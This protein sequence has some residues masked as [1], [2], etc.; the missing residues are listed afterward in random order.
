MTMDPKPANG[1]VAA[2]VAAADKHPECKD[3]HPPSATPQPPM[4]M[5]RSSSGMTTP[6]PAKLPDGVVA[7]LVADTGLPPER[8]LQ[9]ASSPVRQPDGAAAAPGVDVGSPPKWI[10]WIAPS[11]ARRP[12][13]EGGDFEHMCSLSILGRDTLKGG[14]MSGELPLTYLPFYS[15]L[16]SLSLFLILLFLVHL[17]VTLVVTVTVMVTVT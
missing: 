11:P 6:N 14:V 17:L 15:L 3:R 10:L 7:A 4:P 5:P 12:Y 16:S 2:L 13:E 8:T 9:I 1:Q